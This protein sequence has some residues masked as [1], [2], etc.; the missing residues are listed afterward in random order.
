MEKDVKVWMTPKDRDK[1]PDQRVN[2]KKSQDR[3][4]DVITNLTKALDANH[5]HPKQKDCK[6]FVK[7]TGTRKQGVVVDIKIE[8]EIKTLYPIN[9]DLYK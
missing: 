8:I 7:Q 1:T 3:Y 4:V 9:W 2:L 6:V 5:I